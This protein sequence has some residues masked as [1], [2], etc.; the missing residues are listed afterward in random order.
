MANVKHEASALDLVNF[1]ESRGPDNKQL[2]CRLFPRFEG[3]RR[4]HR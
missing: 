2:A 3:P 1:L 4:V